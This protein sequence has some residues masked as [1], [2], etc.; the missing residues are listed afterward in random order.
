[1]LNELKLC[2]FC[3]GEAKVWMNRDGEHYRVACGNIYCDMSPSTDWCKSVAS[4]AG[5]W[6]NRSQV[7]ECDEAK[8]IGRREAIDAFE[9]FLL[10]LKGERDAETQD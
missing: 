3:G 7:T 2:P 9:T 8:A 4:A 5:I 6:N 10:E 1:M